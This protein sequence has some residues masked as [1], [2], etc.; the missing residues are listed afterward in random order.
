[1]LWRRLVF[2]IEHLDVLSWRCAVLALFPGLLSVLLMLQLMS[3]LSRLSPSVVLVF[4]EHGET[5]ADASERRLSGKDDVKHGP[6]SR[7]AQ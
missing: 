3:L 4:V 7:A 6:S 5:V 2:L 1:V